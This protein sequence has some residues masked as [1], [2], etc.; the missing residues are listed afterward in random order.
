VFVGNQA[1]S[2]LLALVQIPTELQPAV[3]AA[4]ARVWTGR[5][6][7]V[8]RVDPEQ[9]QPMLA[10]LAGS[11]DEILR[12]AAHHDQQTPDL[13]FLAVS[14]GA[15]KLRSQRLPPNVP[16]VLTPEELG[17]MR[18]LSLAMR[19]VLDMAPRRKLERQLQELSLPAELGAVASA[20]AHEIG[21]PLTSLLTNLELALSQLATPRPSVDRDLMREP[22]KDALDAARHLARVASDL[23]RAVGRPGRLTVVDVR[24]VIET[25]CRL[26]SEVIEGVEVRW[27]ERRSASAR[28]DETRLCQVLLNLF[29]N[30]GQALEGRKGAAIDIALE[31]RGPFVV[32]DIADNGPG[33]PEPVARRVFE[34]WFTT[35]ARGSGLGLSLC[36]KYLSEMGGSIELVSWTGGTR[37][38]VAVP[39]AP[40]YSPRPT[41]VP[42][43]E[44]LTGRVLVLDDTLLVRRAI[45][46][47]LAQ[48]DVRSVQDIETALEMVAEQPFDVVFVD[49]HLAGRSGFE[50]Y[51]KLVEALPHQAQRVVFL[52][53]GFSASDLA[54]LEKSGLRWIRKPFGAEELRSVVVEL[55][56]QR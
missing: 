17:D 9:E 29:K 15:R 10:V 53:G 46:R 48:H 33:M 56:G 42:D 18:L 26:A 24:P 21:N 4:V 54:Y 41:L 27:P 39:A 35:R 34:P 20:T 50:F 31:V 7:R 28:V 44:M 55:T 38:V 14:E 40:L 47:V 49:R 52:S 12:G 1:Q 3:E 36:R 6:L 23:G 45:E 19:Y 5:I 2:P 22:V 16:W 25:A 8:A 51:E 30:A 37:F 13:T 32:I 43:P 11:E